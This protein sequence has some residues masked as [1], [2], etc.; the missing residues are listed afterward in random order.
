M[1]KQALK[2]L[3]GMDRMG[4][5]KDFVA[6]GIFSSG[7]EEYV[8]AHKPEDFPRANTRGHFDIWRLRAT[9]FNPEG[10]TAGI[11][12]ISQNC[13]LTEG[14]DA[15]DY[16]TIGDIPGMNEGDE[17][18]ESPEEVTVF[19]H[20]W[21]ASRKGALGR[22]SIM[23]YSLET[24][25]YE[26]PVVGYTWDTEQAVTDWRIGKTVGRW[27]GPKLARFLREYKEENPDTRL[28]CIS[29]SLGAH[30]LFGAL[31]ALDDG[32]YEDLLAS[33]TV[34][35][36]T[37]PCSEVSLDGEYGEAVENVVGE[38]HNYWSPNDRT[39]REYYKMMEGEDCLGGCGAKGRMPENYHDHRVG[40]VTDHFSF[41]LPEKG[42]VDEVVEDFGIKPPEEVAEEDL[43]TEI[44]AFEEARVDEHDIP[45][46]TG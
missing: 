41:F 20:G 11:L 42:C 1:K 10:R 40:E 29:N 6:L 16:S 23:R 28:R 14:H 9:P 19:V 43:T 38:L 36:G 26:H 39:L 3:E 35:G 4:P 13:Y 25:G 30:P 31:K 12:G 32:G 2:L 34:L 33:A 15:T 17:D 22:F 7:L 18:K 37:A 45:L 8:H 27:N 5:M 46:E 21:L 24:N 44:E